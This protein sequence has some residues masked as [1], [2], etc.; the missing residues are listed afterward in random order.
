MCELSLALGNLGRTADALALANRAA[1]AAPHQEWPHR[2]RAVHLGTLKRK[3]EA[4]A[5]AREAIRLDPDS[6]YCLVVLFEALVRRGDRRGAAEVA[7]RLRAIYPDYAEAHN[8]LGR[9][10][11]MK[12]RWKEAESHFREALRLLPNEPIYQSNLALAMERQG[13]RK[14]AL[15]MFKQAVRTDP[16]NP[17]ARQQLRSAVDRQLAVGGTILIGF[18]ISRLFLL[19]NLPKGSAPIVI[20][21]LIA[22]TAVGVFLLRGWRRRS[23]DPVVRRFY[24]AE[25]RRGRGL[26]LAYIGFILATNLFLIGLLFASFFLHTGWL[27]A[28]SLAAVFA[29]PLLGMKRVWRSYARAWAA[30]ALRLPDESSA[31]LS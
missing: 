2:L 5:A 29:W 23:L 4:L 13:R 16:N 1:A 27:V 25:K 7:A 31:Q 3:K 17:H 10:A 22:I 18:A 30:G 8:A 14:D 28:V 15:G 12:R 19:G 26:R 11:M 24:E 9:V 6:R 20:A 21:V